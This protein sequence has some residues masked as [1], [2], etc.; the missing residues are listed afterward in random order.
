MSKKKSGL[1][2]IKFKSSK[3]KL[4]WWLHRKEINCKTFSRV[5]DEDKLKVR[6]HKKK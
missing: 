3:S 5:K 2:L 4:T 1:N 6:T